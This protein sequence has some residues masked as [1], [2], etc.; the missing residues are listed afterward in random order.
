M[1]L[2]GF[3]LHCYVMCV[4]RSLQS[5]L[6]LDLFDQ[7]EVFRVSMQFA[8]LLILHCDGNVSLVAFFY[9]KIR[10]TKSAE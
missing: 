7:V 5:K 8:S 10:S 6:K 4:L 3:E 1:H 9:Q 2:F